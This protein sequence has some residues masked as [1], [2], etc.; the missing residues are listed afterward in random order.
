MV[1]CT[2]LPL[3]IVSDLLKA[4]KKLK[5]NKK[6]IILSV[7]K[8]TAPIEWA[9]QRKKDRLI[10]FK[11][12][13]YKKMSQDFK[14]MFHD[15]GNFVGIPISFFKLKKI[16]LIKTI[17]VLNYQREDRLISITLKILN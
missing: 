8:Y 3:I 15:L 13:S 9:F 14:D 12:G 2:L 16:N 1:N 11:K 17:L 4:A 10:P 7:T 6:K 5:K